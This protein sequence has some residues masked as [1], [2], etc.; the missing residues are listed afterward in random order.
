MSSYST[1]LC[2][3]PPH[4]CCAFIFEA[5]AIVISEARHL[6]PSASAWDT[7]SGQQNAAEQACRSVGSMC[8]REQRSRAPLLVLHHGSRNAA[9]PRKC[10]RDHCVLGADLVIALL[11]GD[12]TGDGKVLGA[13]SSL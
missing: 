9:V 11:A 6:N 4:E 1:F 12:C 7:G 5:A 10:N 13:L 8:S 3:G 2:S